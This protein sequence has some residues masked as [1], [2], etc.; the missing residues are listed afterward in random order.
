MSFPGYKRLGVDETATSTVQEHE[1]GLLHQSN[2]GQVYRYVKAG[3]AIAAYQPVDWTSA[4]VASV[5]D[6]GDAIFGVAQVAIAS[7]SYGWVLERGLGTILGSASLAAGKIGII[8]A[9]GGLANAPAEA[10]AGDSVRGITY[11]QEASTPA[12]VAAFLF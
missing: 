3:E 8:T 2:T 7:G 12:G 10:T 9:A 5:T 6:N 4:Y 11:A 1:M